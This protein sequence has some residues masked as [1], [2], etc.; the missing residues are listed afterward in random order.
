M[1]TGYQRLVSVVIV[2]SLCIA[3]CSLAASVVGGLNDR[4][5]P[6]SLLRLT[7]VPIGVMR[8]VVLLESAVPLLVTAVVA[9][10][11]GFLA[12]ELFLRSQLHYSLVAPGAG[13]YLTVLGGLAASLGVIALT[14]PLMDR[15]TGPETARNE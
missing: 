12:A 15:M 10:G 13:Y 7:G 3:G 9:T 6:F 8:R 4:K 11:S 1:L 14:L 5:R 2:I